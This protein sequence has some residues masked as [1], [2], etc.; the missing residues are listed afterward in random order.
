MV[1]T[2]AIPTGPELRQIREHLGLSQNELSDAL[3][4]GSRGARTI[5]N[6][7]QDP[8]FR[9]TPLAWCALRYLLTVVEIYKEMDRESPAHAK[10]SR[11]L[12]AQTAA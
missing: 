9:P 4:F 11:L 5:R 3:G 12:P 8:T 6:W 1:I 7:E 10:I 2:S